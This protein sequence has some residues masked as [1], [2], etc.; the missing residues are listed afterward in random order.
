MTHAN[1]VFSDLDNH[2]LLGSPGE[3]GTLK[4]T[5]IKTCGATLDLTW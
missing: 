3:Y 5:P 4:D 1:L 2:D